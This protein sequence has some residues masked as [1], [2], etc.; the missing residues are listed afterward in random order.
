MTE[1]EQLCR[2]RGL[3]LTG[4]RRVVLQVLEQANDHPCTHEI[5]RRAIAVDGGRIGIATVYRALNSLTAAGLLTRHVFRDG[6]SGSMKACYERATKAPHPHLIDVAT[7]EIVEVDDENLA[8]LLEAEARR[9]GFRLI[10]YR[11]KLFGRAER[12]IGRKEP[13]AI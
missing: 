4:Q 13:A 1:L 3:R 9:M 5:H 2:D 11:L 10:E 6:Q 7:G 8:G 12:P